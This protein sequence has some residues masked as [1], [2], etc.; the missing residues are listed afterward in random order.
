LLEGAGSRR[1]ADVDALAEAVTRLARMA[2]DLGPH[3]ESVDVN[4]VIAGPRG[5]VAVDA[6]V[7]P[8]R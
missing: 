7:I 2:E 8:R 3:L 5:C 1:A 4:P 6:L